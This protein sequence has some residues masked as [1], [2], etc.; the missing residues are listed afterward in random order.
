MG[1]LIQPARGDPTVPE[2]G[3]TGL[4]TDSPGDWGQGA[5]SPRRARLGLRGQKAQSRSK[6]GPGAQIQ[7]DSEPRKAQQ[8]K[9]GHNK[10]VGKPDKKLG[11]LQL[12]LV[13][14][15]ELEGPVRA[16]WA[17]AEKAEARH[18]N[19]SKLTLGPPGSLPPFQIIRSKA[20]WAS[21]EGEDS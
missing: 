6:T 17:E 21:K 20:W 9:R 13:S 12:S 7:R 10:G 19:S 1:D 4:E 11:N 2:R 15:L 3:E 8:P 16:K 18:G 14:G 5:Q